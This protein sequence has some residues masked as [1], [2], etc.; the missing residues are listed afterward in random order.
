MLK[1]H[2]S[3]SAKENVPQQCQVW[4]KPRLPEFSCLNFRQTHLALKLTFVFSPL[5][6]LCLLLLDKCLSKTKYVLGFRLS[7]REINYRE[8]WKRKDIQ[9]ESPSRRNLFFVEKVDF[10]KDLVF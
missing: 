3:G 9:Y 2:A 8:K 4:I 7:L 5:S 10:K 1:I 6:I